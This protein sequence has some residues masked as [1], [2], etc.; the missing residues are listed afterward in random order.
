MDHASDA[1]PDFLPPAVRGGRRHRF[2]ES[3]DINAA[4]REIF[5]PLRTNVRRGMGTEGQLYA[6]EMDA[7]IPG[8][9]LGT[10]WIPPATRG[11]DDPALLAGPTRRRALYD[12]LFAEGRPEALLAYVGERASDTGHGSVLYV[13]IASEDA[14]FAAEYPLGPGRGWHRRE[15]LP[16]PH[17]RLGPTALA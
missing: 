6:I 13:E 8:E 1:A 4:F 11:I 17:R 16:A 10:D 14:A 9:L 2:M 15:L 12:R 5:S 7:C 3:A